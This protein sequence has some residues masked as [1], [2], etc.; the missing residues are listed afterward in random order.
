MLEVDIIFAMSINKYV[1][2]FFVNETT[3]YEWTRE[4]MTLI[5]DI[6]DFVSGILIIL[7]FYLFA[8][9][10]IG[11]R[12]SSAKSKKSNHKSFSLFG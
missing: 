6:S 3:I 9:Q 12:Q 10:D 5:N 1:K 7:M 4:N 2:D 8:R 11:V